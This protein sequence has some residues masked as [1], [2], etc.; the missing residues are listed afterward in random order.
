ML[1]VGNGNAATGGDTKGILIPRVALTQTTSNAPVGASVATSLLVYN[2]ATV[3]DVTPGFYYWD[4]TQW[5]RQTGGAT[6]PQGPQGPAGT[7]GT[8]GT[9]GINGSCNSDWTLVAVANMTLAGT[10]EAACSPAFFMQ[11]GKEYYIVPFNHPTTEF[12]LALTDNVMLVEY[13]RVSNTTN[14]ITSVSTN[15]AG[16]PTLCSFT[17]HIYGKILNAAAGPVTITSNC[18]TSGSLVNIYG[19]GEIRINKTNAVIND[20]GIY[21]FER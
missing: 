14:F 13:E 2:T 16:P 1:D 15:A 20:Y 8:N 19:T 7:N 9:N 12:T 17:A 18:N 4:G 10:A 3:N 11:A 6:G 5:V 21:I